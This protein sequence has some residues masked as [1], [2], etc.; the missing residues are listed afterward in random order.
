MLAANANPTL[1]VVAMEN[2][3]YFAVTVM[4]GVMCSVKRQT[5]TR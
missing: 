5:V 2:V 3:T 4:E 1:V